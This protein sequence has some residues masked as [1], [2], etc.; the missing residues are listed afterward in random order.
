MT[1]QQWKERLDKG[2]VYMDG[3]TGS[4]LQKKGMKR[5]TCAEKWILEHEDMVYELQKQYLEVGSHILL[6]PTFMANRFYLGKYGLENQIEEINTRLVQ[7]SKRAAGQN[8]LVAG[9]MT[10]TGR[11]SA[12]IG[13]V[14]FQEFVDLYQEQ[15]QHLVKAGVDLFCIETMLDLEEAKSCILAIKE[16]CD[17]PIFVSMIYTE[18]G[19]TICGTDM[20]IVIKTFEQLRVDAV[21]MN[22]IKGKTM[23]PLLREMKQYT[24]MPILVKPNAG[25]PEYI[26]GK[27]VYPVTPEQFA[28]EGQQLVEEGAS[29]IG[30]CCGTTPE[31]I[32]LLVERTIRK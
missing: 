19:R 18:D 29:I 9:N 3:A 23:L 2:I 4:N 10:T 15:A 27:N 13:T 26:D 7:I 6:A 24:K 1:K 17:L 22:C 25:L 14:A 28:Y 8:G 21:G 32:K 31:Y 16:V 5:G 30:G 20:E 12:P 11:R